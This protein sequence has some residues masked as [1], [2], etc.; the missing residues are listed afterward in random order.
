[1]QD[2]NER[3]KKAQARVRRIRGFYSSVI[4][5]VLVNLLLLIINLITNPHRL[6]FW[7]VTVIWGIVLI[8]QAINIFTIKDH[9][10]G[11]EWEQKKIRDLMEKDKKEKS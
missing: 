9:F 6:W 7:W 10:L 8:I 11:E 5:F 3:Y 1:M 2:E 4:T